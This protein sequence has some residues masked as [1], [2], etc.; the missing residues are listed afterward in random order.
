MD[1]DEDYEDEDDE[2]EDDEDGSG[3]RKPLPHVLG[4]GRHLPL[5]VFPLT[6]SPNIQDGATL[7]VIE[8]QKLSP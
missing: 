1:E 5:V 7:G 6:A 4:S 8:N 3:R 2:D